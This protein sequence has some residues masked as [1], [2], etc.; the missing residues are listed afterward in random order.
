MTLAQKVIDFATLQSV[1]DDVKDT[2]QAYLRKE[3]KAV[4]ELIQLD[5]GEDIIIDGKGY[6][7]QVMLVSRTSGA[8][9]GVEKKTDSGFSWVG[10]LD[11][12]GESISFTDSEYHFSA[13]NG[14]VKLAVCKQWLI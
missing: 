5:D 3:K 13:V 7:V 14:N 6:S 1:T 11:D 9:A 10:S 4:L 8:K 12:I 2:L